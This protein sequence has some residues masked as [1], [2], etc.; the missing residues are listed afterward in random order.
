[1]I[2]EDILA[3]DIETYNVPVTLDGLIHILDFN[4]YN[5]SENQ[6]IKLKEIIKTL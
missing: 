6:V 5:L 4:K 2:R 3:E 1:M